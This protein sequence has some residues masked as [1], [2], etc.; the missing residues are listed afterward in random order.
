M[1]LVA[2]EKTIPNSGIRIALKYSTIT[3]NDVSW[4]VQNLNPCSHLSRLIP[5]R[6]LLA[7]SAE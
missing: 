5:K 3:T 6:D 2:Q 4:L 7:Y 1:A